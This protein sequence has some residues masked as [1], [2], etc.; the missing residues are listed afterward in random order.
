[1]EPVKQTL[2]GLVVAILVPN[3]Y[4]SK[5]T[6]GSCPKVTPQ[7]NFNLTRFEGV[8]YAVEVFDDNV[9]CM[10]WSITFEGD[11]IWHIKETKDSGVIGEY[12]GKLTPNDE[13]TGALTVKWSAN[14]GSYPLTVFTTDYENYAGV[15]L[16]QQVQKMT[17]LITSNRCDSTAG[18]KEWFSHAPP[19]CISRFDNRLEEWLKN[20]ASTCRTSRK[21]TKE[22]ASVI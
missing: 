1:M 4:A 22:T 13:Q 8:W 21:W 2:I 18:R 5:S 12:N 7:E 15:F 3:L 11:N 16:C 20:L 17:W 19:S 9:K 14:I 6:F 10:E